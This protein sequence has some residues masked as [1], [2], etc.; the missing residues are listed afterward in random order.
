MG[1]LQRQWWPPVFGCR[2]GHM[3]LTGERGAQTERKAATQHHCHV[4]VGS[5][6]LKRHSPTNR[7]EEKTK[8]RWM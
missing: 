7:T 6:P 8:P 3:S 5:S 2:L 1:G 4:T